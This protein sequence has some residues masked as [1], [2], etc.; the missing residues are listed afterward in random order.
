MI[1]FAWKEGKHAREKGNAWRGMDL[2]R[3]RW[4]DRRKGLDGFVVLLYILSS[5]PL[6]C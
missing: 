4:K 6:V 1:V 3:D 2:C 5:L